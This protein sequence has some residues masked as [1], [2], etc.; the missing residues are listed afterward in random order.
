VL[1][2]GVRCEIRMNGPKIPAPGTE[3]PFRQR[4]RAAS[5]GARRAKAAVRR[6]RSCRR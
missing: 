2:G 1:T 6:E 3:T 4:A 5:A